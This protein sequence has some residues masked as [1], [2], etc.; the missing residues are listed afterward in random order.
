MTTETAL[1]TLAPFST[2][3]DVVTHRDLGD[4]YLVTLLGMKGS[5]SRF[6]HE[7]G[8]LTPWRYQGKLFPTSAVA[9]EFMN[10]WAPL[11]KTKLLVV[12][13]EHSWHEALPTRRWAKAAKLNRKG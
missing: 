3:D 5:R 1:P 7:T 12:K 8:L 4:T 11:P 2:A 6:V 9:E 13:W 10:Q